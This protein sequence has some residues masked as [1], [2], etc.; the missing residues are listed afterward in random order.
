MIMSREDIIAHCMEY[1]DVYYDY[2]F[3]DPNWCVIRHKSNRKIFAWIYDR[4]GRVCVNLKCRP[5]MTYFWRSAYEAICPGYH[6]NKEHWNT[7]ILD[8][9]VS[10]DIIRELTAESYAL[11]AARKK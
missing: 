5:E 2:P 1:E 8:G 10:D 9:S 7:V 3:H 6:N 11:T 4:G